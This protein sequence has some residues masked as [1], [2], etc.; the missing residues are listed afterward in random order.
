MALSALD[1]PFC[2]LAV[3]WLGTE[4][5]AAAEHYIVDNFWK[6]VGTVLP[7]VREQREAAA[8]TVGEPED[9]VSS[10]KRDAVE[11]GPHSKHDGAS[12]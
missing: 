11:A 1:F 7:N 6:V 8:A 10:A 12:A 3:R 5:I 2:Y 9:A 4:R